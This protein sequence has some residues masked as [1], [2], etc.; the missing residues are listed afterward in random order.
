MKKIFFL[1]LALMFC[2]TV[3]TGCASDDIAEKLYRVESIE[4]DGIIVLKSAEEYIFVKYTD[5]NLEIEL[6][7]TVVIDFSDSDL[8]P[9]NGK[10]IAFDGSEHRYS[11]ILENVKSIRLADPSKGEPTFA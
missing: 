11:Y 6:H 1:T 9:A 5:A 3:F 8:K 7:D 2:F 4:E 10:F